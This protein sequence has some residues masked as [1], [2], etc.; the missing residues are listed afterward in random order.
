MTNNYKIATNILIS[1]IIES[2]T[3]T[4]TN[5]TGFPAYIP[6]NLSFEKHITDFGYKDSGTDLK[7]KM[8]ASYIQY[9][10]PDSSSTSGTYSSQTIPTWCKRLRVIVIGAGGGGGGGGANINNGGTRGGAGAG[11]GGGGFAVG[12]IAI[13][14]TGQTYQVVVGGRGE[15]GTYESTDGAGGN[16]A[17]NPTVTQTYFKLGTTT[18]MTA[19]VGSW[20]NGGRSSGAD[21]NTTSNTAGGNGVVNDTNVVLNSVT[22]SGNEGVYGNNSNPGE[23]GTINYYDTNTRPTF[24]YGNNGSNVAVNE[25]GDAPTSNNLFWYEQYPNAKPGLGQGGWGGNNSNNDNGYPG[26][27]GGISFVRVYFIR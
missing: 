13:N 27:K 9:E 17:T 14:T 19:N 3:T 16:N 10:G 23:G 6:T 21:S 22:G 26:Q 25:E 20:G 5:Y 18:L 7:T 24:Y 1:D 8:T 12:E 11:G 2:G 15:G 4:S